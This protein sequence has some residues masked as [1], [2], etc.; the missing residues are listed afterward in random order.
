[1]SGKLHR[2]ILFDHD[3]G[4]GHMAKT[5]R[6]ILQEFHWEILSHPPCSPDLAARDF[7]LLPKLKKHLQGLQEDI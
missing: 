2:Q 7:F 6:T 5:I 4:P 3:N 1:M